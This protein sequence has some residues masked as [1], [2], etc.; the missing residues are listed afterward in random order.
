M[1]YSPHSFVLK[2]YILSN[3]FLWGKKTIA[4]IESFLKKYDMIVKCMLFGKW[5]TEGKIVLHHFNP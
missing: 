2:K 3:I 5:E 4:L 1:G